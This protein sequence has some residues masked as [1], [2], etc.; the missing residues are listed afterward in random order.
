MKVTTFTKAEKQ[1]IWQL[2]NI[3]KRKAVVEIKVLTTVFLLPKNGWIKG[4]KKQFCY[5]FIK[6]HLLCFKG[7]KNIIFRLNVLVGGMLTYDN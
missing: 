4:D 5:S 1:L 3:K 7:N 2:N 6:V